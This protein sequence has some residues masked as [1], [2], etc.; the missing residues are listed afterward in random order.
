MV[1]QSL[2]LRR[3][4]PPKVIVL[5]RYVVSTEEPFVAKDWL[6][7]S[8]TKLILL[9]GCDVI[10]EIAVKRA[11]ET[12]PASATRELAGIPGTRNVKMT[13]GT[14]TVEGSGSVTEGEGPFG[15]SLTPTPKPTPRAKM[16]NK[17]KIIESD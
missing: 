5:S 7:T 12:P 1:V 9:G 10:F 2:P 14:G 13:P 3:R 16:I 17:P 11:V 15:E 4:L 6:V 8:P